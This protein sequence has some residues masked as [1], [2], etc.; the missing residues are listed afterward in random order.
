MTWNIEDRT[1]VITGGNSG[2]GFATATEL[3][4]RGAD[5]IVTARDPNKGRAAADRINA[6]TGKTVTPMVLD[7]ASFASIRSFADELTATRGRADVL[8]NNAG[9][10][11]GSRRVTPDGY[12]WTMGVNHL[13]PFLL[14]CLLISDPATLPDRIVNV[15]SEMHRSAKHDL[16]FNELEPGGRYGGSEAYARSKLANILFTRELA[17][18]LEGKDCTTFSL[19]PGV[20]ATRIAQ[21]GDSRLVSLL[22]KTGSRWMRTPEEGAATSVYLATE[23]AIEPHTGGYFSDERLI[24]PNA[25]ALHDGTAV[26][27]WDASAA[28]TG[29][30]T[31]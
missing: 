8:V 30:H 16:E 2:I 6:H 27:L 3:T 18:R 20:V 29:C 13:G 1:V 31:E 9:A 17:R 15:A 28:A 19:H 25:A 22:W 12:E 11:V 24:E 21:D 23:P 4:R 5:V 7:L 14:T 10:F 26:R